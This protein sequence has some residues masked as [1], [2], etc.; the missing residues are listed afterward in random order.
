M[1][2]LINLTDVLRWNQHV[3]IRLISTDAQKTLWESSKHHIIHFSHTAKLRNDCT[4]FKLQ[5]LIAHDSLITMLCSKRINTCPNGSALSN[6]EPNFLNH[7]PRLPFWPYLSIERSLASPKIGLG[8]LDELRSLDNFPRHE[9]HQV[10]WNNNVPDPPRL[11]S[12]STQQ[13]NG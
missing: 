10:N 12:R 9:K 2:L 13:G 4:R 11:A 5:T 7:V 6:P 3:Q 1:L 8:G